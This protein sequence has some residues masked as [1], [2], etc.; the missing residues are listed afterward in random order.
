MGRS[1][2]NALII[3]E[4]RSLEPDHV[5]DMLIRRGFFLVGALP[6]RQ[7]PNFKTSPA[8]DQRHL[9]FQTELAAHVF[10][11]DQTA[12]AIRGAVFGARMKMAQENPALFRGNRAVAFR[13]RTHA[14]KLLVRHDK[15]KLVLRLGQDDELLAAFS[16]PAGRDRDPVLLVEGV[17]E[18][19]GEE[20]LGLRVVVHAPADSRAISIHFPP[21]LTTFR[22]RGQY[23]LMPVC[24][25]FP[26]P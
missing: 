10:R 17:T 9:A 5:S 13:L 20:F 7:V 14:S 4:S 15:K 22:T 21:L 19:A 11:Q 6:F 18:F 2:S 23:K 26:A 25:L 1:N 24:P 16:A 8:A 3:F 12:L